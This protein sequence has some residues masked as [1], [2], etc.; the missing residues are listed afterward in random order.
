MTTTS[1][2]YTKE[3]Y[4]PGCL[5]RCGFRRRPEEVGKWR[6]VGEPRRRWMWDPRPVA[7]ALRTDSESYNFFY[8][9][10]GPHGL[11]LGLHGGAINLRGAA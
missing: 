4:T 6:P 7:D 1:P 11:G 8:N 2:E 9:A 10:Q 3:F 5:Y